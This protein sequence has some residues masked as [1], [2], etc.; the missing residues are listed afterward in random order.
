M[1]LGPHRRSQAPRRRLKLI[2]TCQSYQTLTSSPPARASPIHND[3]FPPGS[4]DAASSAKRSLKFRDKRAGWAEENITTRGHCQ[5]KRVARERRRGERRER[6]DEVHVA[7]ARL[8]RTRPPCPS[9]STV[10][11]R[12]IRTR[13]DCIT[14]AGVRHGSPSSSQ[15]PKTTASP[16]TCRCLWVLNPAIQRA[17][18]ANNSEASASF[19]S[20]PS[21]SMVQVSAWPSSAE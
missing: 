3:D 7:S 19:R 5:T 11:S 20:S 16:F 17:L 21:L 10:I 14:M 1:I 4:A 6:L 18:I 12:P 2:S 9:P 13:L 8:S 15:S